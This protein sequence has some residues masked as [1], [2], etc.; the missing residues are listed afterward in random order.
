MASWSKTLYLPVAGGAQ[1][2]AG[3]V[4][5]ALV[6]DIFSTTFLQLLTLCH[7]LLSQGCDTHQPPEF[8]VQP[9]EIGGGAAHGR[10]DCLFIGDEI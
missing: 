6:P 4:P 3:E 1:L 5:N 10:I 9:E 7:T 2:A 8:L